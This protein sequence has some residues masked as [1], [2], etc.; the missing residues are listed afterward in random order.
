MFSFENEVRKLN[1]DVLTCVDNLTYSI[2]FDTRWLTIAWHPILIFTPHRNQGVRGRV[3]ENRK[4]LSCI[5]L[6]HVSISLLSGFSCFYSFKLL[7]SFF[8][9]RVTSD[10]SMCHM[11]EMWH[12]TEKDLCVVL[13]NFLS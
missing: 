8:F 10:K 12:L 1:F 4:K 11:I 5:Q 3:M 9:L 7:E 6:H 2:I 13:C